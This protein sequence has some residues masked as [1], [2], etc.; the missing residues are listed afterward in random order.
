MLCC[1][2]LTTPLN[3][4]SIVV[5]GGENG[6]LFISSKFLVQEAKAKLAAQRMRIY[7]FMMFRF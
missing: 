4:A 3:K 1:R 2:E 7:L 5:P 6:S